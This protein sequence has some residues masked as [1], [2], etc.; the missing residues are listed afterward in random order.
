VNPRRLAPAIVAHFCASFD[1]ARSRS[2][3][4]HLPVHLR[5][6][7]VKRKMRQRLVF[8]I[9]SDVR[10]SISNGVVSYVCQPLIRHTVEKT[11]IQARPRDEGNGGPR[12]SLQRECGNHFEASWA[13]VAAIMQSRI[14]FLFTR[15]CERAWPRACFVRR[16]TVSFH[17]ERPRFP[18]GFRSVFRLKKPGTRLHFPRCCCT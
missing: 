15:H 11:N 14:C 10:N 3:S 5:H 18:H 17:L 9:P 16:R 7:R 8:S 1:S 4:S 6:K 13:R 12:N 2:E